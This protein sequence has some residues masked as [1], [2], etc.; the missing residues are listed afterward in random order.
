[1]ALIEV[2]SKLARTLV[3]SL[4]SNSLRGTMACRTSTNYKFLKPFEPT[5]KTEFEIS[6]NP[7]EWK[8]V[9]RLLPPKCVPTPEPKEVYPS[10]WKPQEPKTSESPYF[11][12]RNK[13]HMIPVYLIIRKRGTQ[14]IT[15][16]RHV[17]GDVWALEEDLRSYI[18]EQSG[19]E[20]GMRIDELSGNV[21]IRG[22]FVYHV[23]EWLKSLGF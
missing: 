9:E 21:F 4:S 7:E 14:R 5:Y 18:K 23:T 8:F 15:S 6:K 11:V 19:R 20:I 10:G 3:K 17:K 2:G 1:M 16:I 13:N 22:D 12:P